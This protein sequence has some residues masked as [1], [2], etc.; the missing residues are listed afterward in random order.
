GRVVQVHVRRDLVAGDDGD[1]VQV[2]DALERR[3][4]GAPRAA[5]DQAAERDVDRGRVGIAGLDDE[6]RGVNLADGDAVVELDAHRDR[7]ARVE[8]DC[9]GGL[10][11]QRPFGGGGGGG[12]GRVGGR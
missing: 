3:L 9:G 11:W 8:R 10:V 12:G 2:E 5:R 6:R 1:L 7:L 4:V